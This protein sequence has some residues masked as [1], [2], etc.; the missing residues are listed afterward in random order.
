MTPFRRVMIWAGLSLG[1]LSGAPAWPSGGPVVNAPAGSV[2]GTLDSGIRVFKGLPYAAS[3]AGAARWTPPKALPKWSGV[4]EATQ[5]GPACLQ[6]A[7]GGG[8]IYSDPPAAM[9]EDCLSLNIWTPDKARRAPVMVWIH[10]G[11]LTSG[12]GAQSMYDG[13]RMA[14]HGIIVVTINYRLGVFGYLAHP[15]LSAESPEGISGNYGLLDQIAALQWVKANIAAFGG[16]PSNVTIAGESAGGLSVMYLLASPRAHGLFNK[17]IAESAYMVS[18]PE[19]KSAKYGQPSAESAGAA[20][21]GRLGASDLAALRAMDATRLMRGGLSPFG[22]VD[23]KILPRQLVDTFDKGEQAHVPILAGSNSGEIRSLRTL[24]PAAPASAAVYEKAINDRYGDLSADYLK[25]YPASAGLEEAVIA[26]T[27]DALYS[28]T[29]QRLVKK[30]EAVGKPSYLYLWDHGY[31]AADSAGLH[32][33]HA[34]ELPFVFSTLDKTL[35][36]WPTAPKTPEQ[37]ALADRM[38][39]YWT[40]FVKTGR[41]SAPGS[42][43]WTPFGKD[44]AYLLIQDLPRLDHHPMPGMYAFNEKVMCRRRANGGIAWNWNVGISAPPTPGP[45][46]GCG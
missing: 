42:S 34:S 41:P 7:G 19:L 6:A 15:A 43:A 4:R 44:E 9:S 30:Q 40:S 14:Q 18:T 16:D 12:S 13:T 21:A 28:W 22:A 38:T 35:P 45:A 11:S 37:T 33:F 24:A 10:G 17:A 2:S 26:S 3:P 29:A 5:F 20:F 31:P 23:G 39:S 36:V 25:L 27:R 8:S 46:T 32:G 1:L